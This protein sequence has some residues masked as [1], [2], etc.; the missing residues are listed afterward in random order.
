M[1]NGK[2]VLLRALEPGDIDVLYSWEN[3]PEVW[4]VSNTMTPFS[5]YVLEQYII[6]SH[7]DL[8]TNKQ[9]RFVICLLSGKPVGTIDLFDFDPKNLRAGVGILIAEKDERGKGY[10]SEALALLKQYCF[11]ILHLRQLYCSVSKS[12]FASIGLFEN[13]GFAQNGVKKEWLNENGVWVDE[14]FLQCFNN[15]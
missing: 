14:L 5:K 7:N 3:N 6:S 11:N 8:Y 10:A 13:S 9:V 1:L 12:N 4:S 15:L 2:F